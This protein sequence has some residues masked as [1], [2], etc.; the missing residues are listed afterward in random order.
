MRSEDEGM[1]R[2]LPED[3]AGFRTAW[4]ESQQRWSGTIAKARALP[5]EALQ[6][7]VDGEWSFVQTLRH[8]IFV[9]DS[10]VSRGML[11]VREPHH[12]LGLPPTGMKRVQGLDLDARPGLE[13]V[14]RLRADRTR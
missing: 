13:E 12:P 7:C 6:E 8:L 14:L 2:A 4:A 11:G 10:W 9:T 5:E 1:A 3:A